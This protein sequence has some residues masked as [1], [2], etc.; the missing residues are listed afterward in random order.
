MKSVPSK[1]NYT[2]VLGPGSN[3]LALTAKH[4]RTSLFIGLAASGCAPLAHM[5]IV[6]G[7]TGVQDFPIREM[8]MMAIFYLTGAIVYVTRVPERFYPGTFDIFVS[9]VRRAD[10]DNVER[11]KSKVGKANRRG[12]CD[13]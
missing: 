5:A 1:A 9:D 3:L 10:T 11:V 2:G 6:E 13:V 7:M 4:A 8:G 12:H